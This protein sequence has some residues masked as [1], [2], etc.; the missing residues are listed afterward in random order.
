MVEHHRWRGGHTVAKFIA[1]G[2]AIA[3]DHEH[4]P[5]EFMTAP[6]LRLK[7]GHPFTSDL[8]GQDFVMLL[9]AGYRPISLAMG[10]CV[11]EV[12]PSI[13]SLYWSGNPE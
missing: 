12:D 1:L 4:G 5:E 9:R 7:G 8:S 2:T 3:F 6:T 11:Y 13:V 10:S